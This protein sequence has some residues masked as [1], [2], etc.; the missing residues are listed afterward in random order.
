MGDLPAGVVGHHLW[1]EQPCLP[2]RELVSRGNLKPK[3]VFRLALAHPA[4]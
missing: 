3:H 4:I 1:V 2:E